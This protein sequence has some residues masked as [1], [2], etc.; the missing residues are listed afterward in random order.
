MYIFL[1][2]NYRL[3]CYLIHYF[4]LIKGL[5]WQL[6]KS[7]LLYLWKYYTGILNFFSY[8]R[9]LLGKNQT[10]SHQQN[11]WIVTNYGKFKS[12]TALTRDF[13]QHFKLSPC[14]RPHSYVFSRVVNRFMAPGDVSLS[15]LPGLPRTKTI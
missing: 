6:W 9:C 13:C 10:F 15:K 1:N 11:I 5:H 12:S 4:I 3:I 8:S 7:N 14:Q 2:F